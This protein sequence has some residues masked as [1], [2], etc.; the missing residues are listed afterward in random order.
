MPDLL[1]KEAELKQLDQIIAPIP[2]QYGLQLVS[3]FQQ[4]TILRNKELEALR[5]NQKEIKLP[6]TKVGK[7]KG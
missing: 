2:T 7:H 6:D 3:F 1:I 5:E 4:V